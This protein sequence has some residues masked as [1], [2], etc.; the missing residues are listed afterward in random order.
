MIRSTLIAVGVMSLALTAPCAF[1]QSW[2]A[3][4]MNLQ[5]QSELVWQQMRTCAQQAALKFRDH[6]PNGNARREAARL[7]CLRRNHLPI[8][9]D[10]PR[11]Y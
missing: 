11:Y 4:G 5:Q 2:N 6:T 3:P 1:A 9:S 7:D 10:R 8:T